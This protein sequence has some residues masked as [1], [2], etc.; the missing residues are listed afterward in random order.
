MTNQL[1]SLGNVQIESCFIDS[2]VTRD[3]TIDVA[4]LPPRKY[5]KNLIVLV[6]GVH[7]VEGHVG[8]AVIRM[9]VDRHFSVIDFDNTGLLIFHALNPFGFQFNVRVTEKNVD[10]NR[11]FLV[12]GNYAE[13]R[14]HNTKY[15]KLNALVNPSNG[16]EM[17]GLGSILFYLKL[18]NLARRI[19]ARTLKDAI[20][21]GQYKFPKGLFYG[22][23]QLE[24]NGRIF[25]EIFQ[26]RISDYAKILMLNIH[27]GYGAEGDIHYLDVTR[28]R[29]G[30][31]QKK[32]KEA[33]FRGAGIRVI[34]ED[35][36]ILYDI[37]GELEPYAA[38]LV[39]GDQA[40][41]P[42]TLECGTIHGC[43]RIEALLGE[44]ELLRRMVE[45]NMCM[46][47]SKGHFS[48]E[49]PETDPKYIEMFYPSSLTWRRKI[50]EQA[51]KELPK[52]LTGFQELF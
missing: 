12:T 44:L 16:H 43:S 41:V 45:Q 47:H 33:L 19:G 38:S 27:T 46:Q 20:R 30:Q 52:L 50:I 14:S 40:F 25:K 49:F 24:A 21:L 2:M 5:K 29:G 18:F 23:T 42:I 35:D 13:M 39:S 4:Y 48:P 22:G 10:L 34:M 1:S 15:E 36:D 17:S 7:G 51:D 37:S 3:L 9:L 31:Y 32:M 6:S 26:R 28:N 11:N 8:S